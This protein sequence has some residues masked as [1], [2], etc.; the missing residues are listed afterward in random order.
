MTCPDAF[1]CLNLETKNGKTYISSCCI[2]PTWEVETIDFIN[3]E[4]FVRI[5]NQWNKGNWPAE[6]NICYKNEKI[7]NHSRRQA[8]IEWFNNN[9]LPD[10]QYTDVKLLK[11]DYYC[12]N[13]CNLRCAIC[14]P[15]DSI[16]WQKELGIPKEK[17]KIKKN[18][19]T[20]NTN[21]VQ[22]IHF[23]GG[24]PLLINQHWKLLKS[25]EQKNQVVL[26]YNTNATV[27]P[28]QELVDLWSQFKLVI[29]DFSIDDIG[30]R[31]EYQRFPA[32][33]NTVV[34]NLFWLKENMPVNV[35]FEVNTALGILNYYNYP[36]LVNWFEENFS[37]NRVTD[38]V[39]LKTQETI[40]ILSYRNQDK[41][42]IVEYLNILD[43]RRNT[44]WK[45]IFPE[46][47][48]K[49]F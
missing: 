6:C 33:W 36:N 3:D 47:V 1:N 2:M 20:V 21:N 49:L 24:E 11:I 31:F 7:V 16:A 18:S 26:N 48:E 27:L 15:Y 5:R 29:L 14:G 41:K 22:W 32:N 42:Q 17:R 34:N 28:K 19:L 43:Q 8:S 37:T 30:Q 25:I 9:K 4:N 13:T 45:E 39:K 12:G 35:M 46:L 10:E 44:S 40:G 38:P 23:N